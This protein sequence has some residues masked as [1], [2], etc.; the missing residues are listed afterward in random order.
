VRKAAFLDRDGVIN[1]DHGY[2][3]RWEDFEFVPGA[4][5]AMRRLQ[6]AGY[7]LV[8]VTNQSGIARGMYGEAD[9]HAMSAQM[10]EYLAA[11]GVHLA[12][13]EYCPHHPQGEV[14]AYAHACDCRKPEPGMIVRAARALQLDLA[15]SLLFG[16][17]LSD[18][19][20]AQNA[21]VGRYALLATNGDG[22]PGVLPP[23]L[24]AAARYR[25]L[26]EA[27]SAL[28][29]APCG[30]ANAGAAPGPLSR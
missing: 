7:A 19:E 23:S 8:I 12:V 29:A 9:F 10:C 22:E 15:A 17:K 27:V 26:A 3:Y 30:A 16:D 28:L 20:A 14:A 24:A 6:D 21:G 11:R 2:V 18:L 5:E 25:S 1:R 4:V 13:I